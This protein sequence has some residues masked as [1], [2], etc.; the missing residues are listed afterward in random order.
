MKDYFH[1]YKNKAVLEKSQ[2]KSMYFL[3][4]QKYNT[5]MVLHDDGSSMSTA[6]FVLV[7]NANICLVFKSLRL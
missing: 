2:N 4:C 3:W 1:N 6:S 7:E 5:L